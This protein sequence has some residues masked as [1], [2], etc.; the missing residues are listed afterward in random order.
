MARRAH[1]LT[2][3]PACEHQTEA[4]DIHSFERT[5]HT[6]KIALRTLNPTSYAHARYCTQ[7]QL[8]RYL[9][10]LVHCTSMSFKGQISKQFKAPKNSSTISTWRG[11][12]HRGSR[13]TKHHHHQRQQQPQGGN[14]QQ[15]TLHTLGLA[16]ITFPSLAIAAPS[17]STGRGGPLC[18]KVICKTTNERTKERTTFAW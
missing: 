15:A 5:Q 4:T 2:F 13:R 11:H 8:H 18:G 1:G 12:H 17:V 16:L 7:Q 3:L 14:T 10:R 6:R 9:P